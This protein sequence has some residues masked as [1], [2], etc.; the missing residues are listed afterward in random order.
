[1]ICDVSVEAGTGRSGAPPCSATAII[2][3]T[4]TLFALRIPVQSE[5]MAELLPLCQELSLKVYLWL[6]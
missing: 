6:F 1:M 2:K 3:L 4:G 5:K